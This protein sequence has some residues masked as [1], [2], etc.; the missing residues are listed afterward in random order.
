M[1]PVIEP[2]D[3]HLK[4]R[5]IQPDSYIVL[6]NDKKEFH[7]LFL[8]NNQE[9]NG[10]LRADVFSIVKFASINELKDFQAEIGRIIWDTENQEP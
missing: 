9:T 4:I 10:K 3:L 1:S 8:A 7:I 5:P 6:K 2:D